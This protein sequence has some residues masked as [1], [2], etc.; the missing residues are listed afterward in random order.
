MG[1]GRFVKG[2]SLVWLLLLGFCF[3]GTGSAQAQNFTGPEA[4]VWEALQKF[5]QYGS[6][7]SPQAGLYLS[8]RSYEIL[9]QLLLTQALAQ[10]SIT[11]AEAEQNRESL[12]AE[13]QRP[14][15]P[16]AKDLWKHMAQLTGDLEYD[17]PA[18]SIAPGG[19]EATIYERDN[20]SE[21]LKFFNEGGWKLGLF[22]SVTDMM[23]TLQNR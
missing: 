5:K 3:L 14:D 2:A 13:L 9:T 18:I 11:A 6:Q 21:A 10:G 22:E 1:I 17:N 12:T 4:K 20:P 8:K 23:G 16:L 15:S 7:G 19:Q